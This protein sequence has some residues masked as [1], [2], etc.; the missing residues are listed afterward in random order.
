MLFHYVVDATNDN[1]LHE[2]LLQIITVGMD[3]LDAGHA[4]SAWPAC[5]P[6]A[7]QAALSAKTGLRDRRRLFFE[8]FAALNRTA[9]SIQAVQPSGATYRRASNPPLTRRRHA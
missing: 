7:R 5:I 9:Q 1:W 4:L 8:A 6:A 3:E 2:T